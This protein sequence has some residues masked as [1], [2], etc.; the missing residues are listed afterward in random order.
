MSKYLFALQ[1]ETG[2]E[3]ASGYADLKKVGDVVGTV[4]SGLAVI[5]NGKD[6]IATG[7]EVDDDTQMTLHRWEIKDP[8]DKLG[9]PVSKKVSR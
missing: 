2:R 4:E 7:R 8:A 6:V 5:R 9:K 1:D 3:L